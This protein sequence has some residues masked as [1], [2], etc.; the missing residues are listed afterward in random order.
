MMASV[1][2]YCHHQS[3]DARVYFFSP[4]NT[5]H[6][7]Y[8]RRWILYTWQSDESDDCITF[9]VRSMYGGTLHNLLLSN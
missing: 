4:D 7:E 3:L 5:E 6:G 8:S 1:L 2:N 9:R